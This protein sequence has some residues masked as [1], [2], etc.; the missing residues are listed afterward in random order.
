MASFRNVWLLF[1][2]AIAS[3]GMP[4]PVAG[5]DSLSHTIF[6]HG[7]G[8]Y[9]QYPW[10]AAINSLL[11]SYTFSQ[12]YLQADVPNATSIW[13][14]YQYLDDDV[15]PDTSIM[16]GYSLGG[17]ASRDLA[18]H[19]DIGGLITVGSPHT[20]ASGRK[21]RISRVR[22]RRRAMVASSIPSW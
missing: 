14:W 13:A 11:G 3:V 5:Q 2:A 15:K 6:V 9:G 16:V 21:R 10:G 20:T 19:E 22:S 12:G 18:Q 8:G 7:A 4:K 1:G 17:V